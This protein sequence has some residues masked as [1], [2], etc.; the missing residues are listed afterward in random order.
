[1]KFRYFYKCIDCDF[2]VF[3][4]WEIIHEKHI[5][6][7]NCAKQHDDEQIKYTIKVVFAHDFYPIEITEEEYDKTIKQIKMENVK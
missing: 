7:E 1:M 2:T 4:G 5:V 6:F 3:I